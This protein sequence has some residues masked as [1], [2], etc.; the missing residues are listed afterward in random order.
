M[1]ITHSYLGTT[2]GGVRCLFF[3]LFEDYIE[4]QRGLS[5]E[6]KSELERFARNLGDAGAVVAPFPGDVP[7]TRQSVLDKAWTD[8]EINEVRQTPAVLMIDTDFV[9]FNPRLHSWVLFHF[10]RAPDKDY[11]PKLRSLFE[12]V[13]QAA[14][15]D[16][17]PFLIVREALRN[18]ALAKA[19]KSF[20]MEPGA[21]GIS[22]D[23][24][25]GWT[26]LKE[27]LRKA[28]SVKDGTAATDSESRTPNDR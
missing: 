21:F 24:R 4:A 19:A 12:K 26:S 22:V 1:W 10:D 6:V 2:R 8:P 7:A 15:A 27:Y 23:L 28:S 16:G 11:A 17:N 25:A 5:D 13:A 20:K 3:L 18:E 14:G 9:A